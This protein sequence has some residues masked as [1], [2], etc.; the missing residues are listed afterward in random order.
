MRRAGMTNTGS[1]IRAT[2]VICHEMLSITTSVRVKRHEIADNAGQ[3]VAEGTL[4]TEHVAVEPAHQRTGTRAGEEGDRHALHVVEDRR[5]QVEDEPFADVG[6]QP[7]GVDAESGIGQCDEGDQTRQLEDG[8]PRVSVDDR[9]DDL[10]RP[11]RA[12]PRQ[13]LR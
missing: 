8:T 9:V 3:R 11:A 7:P 1:R 12:S 4:R 13:E 5:T 10:V 2:S 6:R